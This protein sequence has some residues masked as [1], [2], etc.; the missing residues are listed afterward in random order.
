MIITNSNFIANSGVI[1]VNVSDH[2]MVFATRNKITSPTEKIEFSG[3]S[4]RNYDPARFK[5]LI[6]E[7]NWDL[8]D[9]ANDPDSA[10]RCMLQNIRTIIDQMCP[11]KKFRIN[12]PKDPWL[13][14]EILEYIK[15]KG[16]ALKRAKRTNNIDDW[17]NARYM[18]N[19]C[20][21]KIRTAKA[22]L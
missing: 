20:L 2:D 19:Q 6:R 14:H 1:D 17:T 16:H 22:L 9:H 13:T 11:V 21:S 3:R 10:W 4:Y 18:R 12:K 5:Q 8:F 15:D 7:S